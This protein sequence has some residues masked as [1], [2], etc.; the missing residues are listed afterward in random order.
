MG[1]GKTSV[2]QE[3]SKKFS[4]KATQSPHFK[5]AALAR[6]IA[7]VFVCG[8]LSGSPMAW[9]EPSTYVDMVYGTLQFGG[10]YFKVSKIGE[11][12]AWVFDYDDY[13]TGGSFRTSTART[14]ITPNQDIN[15]VVDFTDL[16]RPFAVSEFY[17]DTD[18]QVVFQ[19]HD[20]NP[21]FFDITN[22]GNG[23]VILRSPKD[24]GSIRTYLGNIFNNGSGTVVFETTGN[25]NLFYTAAGSRST[26]IALAT[27]I[28]NYGIG[29]IRIN[30]YAN[31]KDKIDSKMYVFEAGSSRSGDFGDPL[32]IKNSDDGNYDIRK[33][34]KTPS[35]RDG[36]SRFV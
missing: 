5:P 28:N 20:V 10:L 23:D 9:G 33:L 7:G 35:L 29:A 1:G 14:L 13:D 17:H 3:I 8:A 22:E 25:G 36:V 15:F 32:D 21:Q 18:K 30:G 16:S 31:N 27:Q 2:A 34:F 4:R 11:E 19:F 26:D 6:A 12:Y 24:G